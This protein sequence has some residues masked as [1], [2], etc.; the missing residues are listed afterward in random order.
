M[1]N[2]CWSGHSLSQTSATDRG[3]RGRFGVGVAGAGFALLLAGSMLL[4]LSARHS[5]HQ[6]LAQVPAPPVLSLRQSSN[7]R[8]NIPRKPDAQAVLGQLPLIFE[9]NVGQGNAAAKFLAHGP[10]YGL[11]LDATGA[12]LG[13]QAQPPSRGRELVV[14]M[15]LVGAN[16]GAGIAGTDLLPGKS[17]Y[18]VGSDPHQWRTGISQFAGV[19]YGNIY[20][21]ID[22]VFYGNQGHLEYD[23]RVA[24]G[25]DPSRAELQFDGVGKLEIRNGDLLFATGDREK[26]TPMLRMRRPEI[27][28]RNGDHRTPVEGRFVLRADHRV[29]FEVGSYDRGR[30]LIIDPALDFSSYFGIITAGSPVWVAVNNDGNIYLSGSTTSDTGFPPTTPTTIGTNHV[31]VAKIDPSSPPALDYLTFIGGNGTDTSMGLGVDQSGNTYVAGNTTSTDFPHTSLAYQTAPMTKRACPPSS[32]KSLFV[33]ALA[34]GG[35]SFNYSSYISGN[36]DDEAS[37]V[38][39]DT[40]QDVFITGTTTSNNEASSTVAFPASL[41]PAPFQPTAYSTKQFFV[42]KVNTTVAG[43][44]G[45]AYSTY[46]GGSLPANPIATG[47]GI[48]VDST[49]NIYF[50]GTTNFYNSGSGLFGDSGTSGD[51]PIL[52][53]YQP[54]L[55]T[56]PPITLNN[57]NACAAPATTPYP[58][59]A[60]IAKIN[61]LGGTGAQLLYS[62]YLGGKF[63]DTGTAIAIDSTYV[64]LTGST[65]SPDFYLPPTS[66]AYQ[67]CLNDPTATNI[68]STA[69][70]PAVT[71]PGP[72]DAYIARFT[73]PASSTSGTPNF[74]AFTYF[75]YLGGTGNDAGNGIAVDTANDAL[76]T[77]YTASTD[78]PVTTHAIQGKLNGAQNSFFAHLNTNAT[79]SI[80]GGNY[81]T[82]FGGNRTDDGTSIAVDINLNT[83]FAGSTTSGTL[84]VA[85]PLSPG[86]T[87]LNGTGPDAFAVK[88]GPQSD[89]SLTFLQVFP[90]GTAAAGNQVT[91]T[92]TLANLGPDV[93]T[94]I[95]L[96]G[97]VPTGVIFNSAAV[98]GTTG[99]GGT[100]GICS[101]ATSSTNIICTI[102]ALQAGSAVTVTFVVTPLIPGTFQAIATVSNPT[103]TNTSN[104]VT[105]PFS[106]T[107]FTVAIAPSSQTVAAGTA[108]QYNVVV[109]PTQGVFGANVSL[110]CSQLP[111]GASCN[112][113]TSTLN[114][115]SGAGSASTVLNLSTTA[116]P[117][118]TASTGWHRP[119]YAFWL[120]VPGMAFLGLAGAGKKR[121]R[122][123]LF[124]L[125]ALMAFFAMTLLQPACSTPKTLP[126]VS[127]TPSGSYPLTI[128][129]TS[130][131]LTKTAS[132]GLTV[133]P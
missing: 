24:P 42:T 106:A 111:T 86:G 87:S 112:F 80:G 11:S 54:C 77:G 69:S 63:N 94:S 13:M 14:R 109:A 7:S 32:C 31:F 48:A 9:P 56:I 58:T 122:N 61:P 28:Q 53:S 4:W 85:D 57:P 49:G 93:A 67:G 64:Y 5:P 79:A 37:G 1:G 76:V 107:S 27:Y 51:F 121:R 78:F 12:V 33:S 29:S 23:F 100:T 66:L 22:L 6:P 96:L 47:G 113:A 119:L 133:V 59:D 10:G 75:S 127:G 41:L 83:Y 2:G 128:T 19:R 124:G 88:L 131:S 36:G 118:I 55:D 103:N 125:I 82:Y 117:V 90:S 70:C 30:E 130:G 84:Q 89:L 104:T 15:K 50:S 97:Q 26:G 95:N 45:I 39:I 40:S 74:V 73:N 38:A 98:S 81:V 110:S 72:T 101:A 92:Y 8:S 35:G 65:N 114:L 105:A 132:F 43:V 116:Q 62:T 71:A 91:I 68:S 44:G 108:A 18:L 123:I 17:N 126:T 46:F 34:T 20:P 3:R 102:P 16:L 21:G 99:T 52:N 25:A 129:A 60:F 115:S 120:A